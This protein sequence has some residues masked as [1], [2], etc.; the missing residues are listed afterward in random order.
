[1][2]TVN[3]AKRNAII[4]AI[5]ETR[6]KITLAIQ[7]LQQTDTPISRATLYRYARQYADIQEAIEESRNDFDE[8]MVDIA[9]WKLREALK[10]GEQWAIKYT[11][12]T[13]GKDRG[14]V[15]RHDIGLALSPEV[16][17]MAQQLGINKADIVREFE[18]L[19]RAEAE[20]VNST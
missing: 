7:L 18:A 1:M 10:A 17:A 16:Q 15:E 13:K 5:H 19:I 3:K 6:G 2:Q 11:L 9:E 14:Y 12:S 8:S 20:R 4:Q